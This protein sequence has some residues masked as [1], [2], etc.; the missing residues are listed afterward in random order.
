MLCLATMVAMSATSASAAPVTA[1]SEITTPAHAKA[2][3]QGKLLDSKVKVNAK[4]RIRGR[5]DL[6]DTRSAE[7]GLELVVVQKLVAGAWIDVLS[8]PCRPNSTFRLSVSFSL[9]A[10]YSLRLFHPTT[11]VS[12]NTFVLSVLG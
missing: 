6:L 10:E 7:R 8:T 11:A 4:A 12:S 5:L 1:G 2:K 9:S 3:L